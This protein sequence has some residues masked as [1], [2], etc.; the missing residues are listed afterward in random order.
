MDALPDSF[1]ALSSFHQFIVYKLD[2]SVKR[3]GKL[4]KLPID[5]KT[6]K[7]IDAHDPSAWTDHATAI[8]TAKKLGN[9]YGVGFVLTNDDP[10]FFLDIDDC[11]QLDNQWSSL[12]QK[13]CHIFNGAAIEVSSSKKGLHILGCGKVPAHSCK[14]T[15]LKLEFYTSKRFVALTGI[16]IIGNISQ[17]FTSILP[18][19]INEYFPPKNEEI[20][21]NEW[22]TQPCPEWNGP[23]D[24]T[25][26]L[27]LM[28]NS[29]N[30]EKIKSLWTAN[31]EKLAHAYPD[32][33]RL[34]GYNESSADMA[35]AQ[36][37]AFWTGNNC[38]RIKNLML[39][40]ELVREKW[41]RLDYL[42]RTIQKACVQ[43][44]EIYQGSNTLF[45]TLGKNNLP[46]PLPELPDVLPFDCNY[47]PE[48]LREYVHDI[49]ERMQ[50]PPDF[51]AVTAFVMVSAIC[52]RKISLRP[53]KQDDW[54][55][56]PNLWGAIVGNSGV[57]KSPTM[58]EILSPLKK[59]AAEAN[60]EFNRKIEEY[61]TQ[62]R[63]IE[64]QQ[65]IQKSEAKKALKGKK[66][67]DAKQI[68]QSGEIITKPILQRFIT[69]NASYEALGEILMENP[70]GILVEADEIIGLLKQLDASGQE[71]ARSFYLTAADG[72]KSYTFDRIIRGKGLH[73]EAVC[74]SILGGIQPGV[75]ADYVRQAISGGSKAD[76]LLQRFG[77]M[78]YPDISPDWEEID[79]H[80]DRNAR[81]RI[82]DLVKKLHHLNPT[83]IGA[84]TDPYK[85]VPFL[86]FDNKA[87][88]L[89]SK[90]RTD[91]EHRLRSNE[92]HPT[93]ISH[94]AKYRKLI[95]S[96]ALLN[97]LCDEAKGPVTET[98]L[99]RAIAYGRYLES[100]ARRIYSFVTRPDIDAAKTVLKRLESRKLINPFTAR[101]L[102][103]KGWAGL[104][105]PHQAKL[106]IDLLVEYGHLS[107]EKKTN[108]G[109][110]T[111]LYHW[112]EVTV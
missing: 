4:D 36:Y 65:S 71:V 111:E 9:F 5:F 54:T 102:Y 35:L 63:M 108:E 97:H 103:K 98:A 23:T 64:L 76:G 99:E 88:L 47:L 59:L 60:Q 90:W 50:C 55:V 106:A 92:E 61:A 14:N 21:Q 10:F 78:V 93:M 53:M 13:L 17:E 16:S 39:Q 57:M 110:P 96:L 73:I 43:Q 3:N 83:D 77:L 48:I 38:E 41:D 32:S 44:K 33:S 75:L 56:I 95:T 29:K 19:F 40:S 72:D 49:S 109:R 84:E 31:A 94:L 105:T 6:G 30:G 26:L 101:E 81:Q 85:T 100:H 42:T 34:C 2:P 18:K 15:K 12:A 20:L 74:I 66:L 46:E 1:K 69:N 104:S 51:A 82:N 80:P 27:A 24:D 37:L 45:L 22:T 86:R 107:E 112:C 91:L 62:L 70:N 52:G 7:I 89:F 11:L 25:Q 79:R 28:F 68:L 67:D 58:K 87:Q 8:V